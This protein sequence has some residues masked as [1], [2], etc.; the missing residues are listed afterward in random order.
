[1][2]EQFQLEQPLAIQP[3]YDVAPSQ[4]VA[5]IRTNSASIDREGVFLWWM[6]IPRM[7]KKL[8]L[9]VSLGCTST[10]QHS[11]PLVSPQSD[12]RYST[13]RGTPSSGNGKE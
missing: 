7:V 9:A 1:M 11:P 5:C 10:P 12:P 3:R 6:L 2:A 8:E 4:L 13:P